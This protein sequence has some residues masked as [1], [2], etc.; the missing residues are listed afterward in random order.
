MSARK[1]SSHS[2]HCCLVTG[3]VFCFF[4]VDKSTLEVYVTY[5]GW[6]LS[7]VVSVLQNI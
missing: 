7:S 6:M 1:L 4:L 3:K 5:L 2:R